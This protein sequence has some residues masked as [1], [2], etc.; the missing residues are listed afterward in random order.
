MA[1]TDK[2]EPKAAIPPKGER[3][4]K[5]TYA[6]DKRNPGAYLVRVE[7]PH[8]SAFAGRDVP[9]TRKDDS[10]SVETLDVAV[11]AGV[12]TETGKPVALYRFVAKPR[13]EAAADDLP[14]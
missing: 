5:A 8:A 12:D 9:V 7:G 3:Q 11:W 4:H 14:F 1:G 13:D 6:R 2:P 10:E